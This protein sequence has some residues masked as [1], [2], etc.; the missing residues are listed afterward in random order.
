MND[1]DCTCRANSILKRFP[2]PVHGLVFATKNDRL[3]LLEERVN[4]LEEWL[5][6]VAERGTE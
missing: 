3:E 5:T 2:C 1:L 4:K 6:R